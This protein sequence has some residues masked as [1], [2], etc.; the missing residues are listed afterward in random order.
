MVDQIGQTVGPPFKAHPFTRHSCVKK[1]KWIKKVC[2]TGHTHG[3][4][5]TKKK[6]LVEPDV[7]G[8]SHMWKQLLPSIMPD[9]IQE[10]PGQTGFCALPFKLNQMQT[11]T[12]STI[13]VTSLKFIFLVGSWLGC[14]HFSLDLLRR[15]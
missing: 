7:T 15:F 4:Y 1:I 11:K 8:A 5:I 2:Q 10:T 6:S 3:A 13:P 9:F 14:S 12:K